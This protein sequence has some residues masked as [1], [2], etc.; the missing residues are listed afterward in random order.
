MNSFRL[1]LMKL[2]MFITSYCPLYFMVMV[3]NVKGYKFIW[4]PMDW[5]MIDI[6]MTL[7]VG[8]LLV[9][10]F[11]SINCTWD[12]ATTKWDYEYKFSSFDKTEDSVISYMMT[13]IVPLLSGDFLSFQ[14]LVVNITLYMLIA[15]MYV[16]L[17]LIYFNPL[18]LLL[19]YTTYTTNNGA[20][21]I[22]N[23]SHEVLNQNVDKSIRASYLIDKIY[24][25]RKKDN[26]LI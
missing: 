6:K 22:S 15:I 2:K 10:I 4:N 12:L 20:V 1:V 23:I 19:G 18:W 3:L 21:I 24:L 14:N 13:Y 8:V 16:R 26:P 11:I 17:N 9:L 5:E 7:F 25:I